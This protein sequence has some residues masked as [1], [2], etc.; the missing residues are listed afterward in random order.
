M[1][2]LNP[3]LHNQLRLGIMAL[4]SQVER[5]SF[6][7]LAEKTGSTRGNLSVQ[8]TNLEQAGYICIEKTF[9]KRKPVTYCSI[10][11]SGRTAMIEYTDALKE[12]LNF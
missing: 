8:L 1:R 4:L 6:T 2:D 3:L 9:E 5:A 12:Y 11:D 10:T 7:Y